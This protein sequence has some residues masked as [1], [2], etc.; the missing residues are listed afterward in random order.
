MVFSLK[1]ATAKYVILGSKDLCPEHVPAGHHSV[2]AHPEL[3]EGLQYS[4]RHGRLQQESHAG[5]EGLCIRDQVSGR[6]QR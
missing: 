6:E 5:R 3:V 2:E 4:A 1:A